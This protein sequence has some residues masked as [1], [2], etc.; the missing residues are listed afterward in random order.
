MKLLRKD[1]LK[2]SQMVL[3]RGPGTLCLGLATALLAY[4]RL[5]AIKIF[6]VNTIIYRVLIHIGIA[7]LAWATFRIYKK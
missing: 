5:L 1:T 4:Y 7:V 6:P 2:P 3:I